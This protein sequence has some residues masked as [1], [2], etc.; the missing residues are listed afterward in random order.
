[1][2]F[3]AL[4]ILYFSRK[5]YR[6]SFR[7][8]EWVLVIIGCLITITAFTMDY[9]NYMKAEFSFWEVLSF[10]HNSEL[11]Q[12]SAAYVPLSFNW[13]VFGVGE[14]FFLITIWFFTRRVMHRNP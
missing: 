3:M 2:I 4:I 1:M 5:G 14:I 8:Q 11:M 7:W 10:S 12:F 13:Y 9:Y 6:V